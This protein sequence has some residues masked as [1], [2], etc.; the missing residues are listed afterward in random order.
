MKIQLLITKATAVA[1]LIASQLGVAQTGG[2]Y[3]VTAPSISNGTII[4]FED[5][6]L[7]NNANGGTAPFGYY[8]T[9]SQNVVSDSND[10]NISDYRSNTDVDLAVQDKTLSSG[11]NHAQKGQITVS[12]VAT[13]EY[14]Y[15]TLSVAETG[16]YFININ[17]GHSSVVPK[18]Y[19][20]DKLSTT[21]LAFVERLVDGQDRAHST[22]TYTS[23]TTTVQP[24]QDPTTALLKTAASWDLQTVAAGEP[25]NPTKFNL[26]AGET[27]V[28]KFHLKD[29]GPAFNWFQFVNNPDT[30]SMDDLS[31]EETLMVYPNPSANGLFN[32]NVESNWKVYSLL[33]VKVTEG[34]GKTVDLSGRAKGA[35]ILKTDNE[36]KML[37]LK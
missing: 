31:A 12:S 3:G 10:W 6:D 21:D 33:G 9:T 30:L 5:F 18:R 23:G 8:D 2:P 1:V 36:S 15:Y 14:L 25:G 24:D 22:E 17:Y 37:I 19:I 4:Q 20:I 27:F 26:E 34:N 29:T 13:D 35:Y 16:E 7:G 28:L 11:A 32:I